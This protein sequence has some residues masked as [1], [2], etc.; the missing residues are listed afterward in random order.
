MYRLKDNKV[1]DM[2]W[3]TRFDYDIHFIVNNK[4]KIQNIKNAASGKNYNLNVSQY[5]LPIVLRFSKT[6]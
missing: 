2:R 5:K 4:L 3:K 6:S 1:S